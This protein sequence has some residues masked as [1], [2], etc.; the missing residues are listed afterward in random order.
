MCQAVSSAVRHLGDR[1]KDKPLSLLVIFHSH[2]GG[3]QFMLGK[4]LDGAPRGAGIE[5]YVACVTLS[6]KQGLAR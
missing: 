1:G 4:T 2:Q 6:T 3:M 5:L